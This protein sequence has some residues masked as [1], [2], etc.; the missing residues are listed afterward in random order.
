VPRLHRPGS[1]ESVEQQPTEFG[2]LCDR[3]LVDRREGVQS[4]DFS[5]SRV[6]ITFP[7]SRFEKQDRDFPSRFGAIRREMR[8]PRI[9][10]SVQSRHR[11]TFFVAALAG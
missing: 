9:D 5:M 3:Q 1:L 6:V 11:E 10:L 4:S 8:P 2:A 7:G